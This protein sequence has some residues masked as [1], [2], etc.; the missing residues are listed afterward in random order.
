MDFQKSP[1]VSVYEPTSLIDLLSIIDGSD[2]IEDK[3]LI[4]AVLG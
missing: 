4:Q 1:F 2:A 3:R